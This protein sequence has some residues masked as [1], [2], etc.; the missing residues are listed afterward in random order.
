MAERQGLLR[1]RRLSSV[2][3]LG[4]EILLILDEVAREQQDVDR[5]RTALLTADPSLARGL[6]PQYFEPVQDAPDDPGDVSLDRDDVSYDYSGVT[7]ESPKDLP[8]DEFEAIKRLLGDASITVGSPAEAPEGME[9]AP[10]LS[11]PDEPEWT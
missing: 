2:Q 10:G 6:Y 1:G 9:G 7:W 11:E 3:Q 8:D 4:L 5:M